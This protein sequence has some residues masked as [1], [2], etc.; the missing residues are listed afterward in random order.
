MSSAVPS[1][2]PGSGASKSA[3]TRAELN[4]GAVYQGYV[5]GNDVFTGQCLVAL[6]SIPIGI[7]CIVASS[8][9]GHLI[10]ITS[11]T[12]P[13]IGTNVLVVYRASG[14]SVLIGSINL[15]TW[16]QCVS[17]VA[18][19]EA[20][21]LRD[22]S[23]L[24]GSNHTVAPMI[25]QAGM[26]K[27][28]LS[29][30]FDLTS[31]LSVGLQILHTFAILKAGDLAKVETCLLNNMVR[32]VARS[33]RIHAATGDMLNYVDGNTLNAEENET[34]YDHEAFG[35]F[36]ETDPK[37]DATDP[38]LAGIDSVND[39]GR[40]R[41]LRMRGWLAGWIQEWVKDPEKVIGKISSDISG[42][43]KSRFARLNDGS[44]IL[45]S[46]ADIAIERVTRIPVPRRIRTPDDE[47]GNVVEELG[48]LDA[49][50]LRAWKM[51]NDPADAFKTAFQLREYARYLS[52]FLSL[53]RYLQMKKDWEVKSESASEVPDW[54]ALESDVEKVNSQQPYGYIDT[55]SCYR[56]LRDGS[57]VIVSGDGSSLTMAGG[58]V[59]LAASKNLHMSAPGDVTITAGQ[60]VNIGARKSVEVTAGVGGLI[61]KARTWLRALC[62]RG[63]VYIKSDAK[64]PAS[65]NYVAPAAGT[66]DEPAEDVLDGAI[67]LDSSQGGMRLNS[68]R[69]M[70]I[71]VLGNGDNNGDVN[72]RS[73]SVVIATNQRFDVEATH[74]IRM[75]TRSGGIALWAQREFITRCINAWMNVTGEFR[76]GKE[77]LTVDSGGINAHTA[78]IARVYASSGFYGKAVESGVPNHRG[79]I[80]QIDDDR[81]DTIAPTFSDNTELETKQTEIDNLPQFKAFP[82]V[83]PLWRFDSSTYSL[84][85]GKPFELYESLTDQR[86]RLDGLPAY[87]SYE[88]IQLSG[89][90]PR[91][92]KQTT[93]WPGKEARHYT[94]SGGDPLHIPSSKSGEA[95]FTNTDLKLSKIQR[96]FLK[97]Q[98]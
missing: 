83:D 17:N 40:W 66:P 22:T 63:S 42:A 10:G 49:K 44:I 70:G 74:G 39:T 12:V 46:V 32:I 43:G 75:R 76:V 16:Q 89:G 29:G 93:S 57:I 19:P 59:H 77:M 53:S 35:Q 50:M 27:D 34:S 78:N 38:N 3:A 54:S 2:L 96:F 23:G 9:F 1:G 25:N 48:K 56:I 97:L 14:P 92:D 68:Q 52:E 6:D 98:P 85:F 91:T 84:N 33:L 30:E 86:I 71:T 15:G 95:L 61:L 88:P 64:D 67:V 72:D 55:Y 87:Q 5:T 58:H 13:P 31:V 62:E 94:Y 69:T 81:L 90:G 21:R 4:D 28:M 36:N 80:F 45:Q 65:Q 8:V 24:E 60:D 82:T 73:T 51:P 20:Q 26:S 18:F 47:D 7:P 79:H 41:W 37:Y 11:A